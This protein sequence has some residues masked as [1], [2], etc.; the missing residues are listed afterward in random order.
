ML[1]RSL[2]SFA[3]LLCTVLVALADA[4]TVTR[5]YIDGQHI[6]FN[7]EGHPK[8]KGVNLTLAYPKSWRADEGL[9]PNIVQKFVSEGGRGLE[10]MMIITKELPLPT[11]RVLTT[12]EQVSFLAP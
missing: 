2:I 7:T 3:L 1:I 8:A 11:G 5:A 6:T 9:R 12:Q 4:T 10:I